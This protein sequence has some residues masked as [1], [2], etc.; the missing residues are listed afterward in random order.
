MSSVARVQLNVR[1]NRTSSSA[2]PR[3]AAFIIPG[4]VME[5]MTAETCPMNRTAVSR[6]YLSHSVVNRLISQ[7]QNVFLP[8]DAAMLARSWES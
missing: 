1:A 5:T 7:Q 3:T 8:R 2:L 6:L 4:S